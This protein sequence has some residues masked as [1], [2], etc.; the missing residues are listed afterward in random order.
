VWESEGSVLDVQGQP[1]AP[2]APEAGATP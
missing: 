2:Y 1:F